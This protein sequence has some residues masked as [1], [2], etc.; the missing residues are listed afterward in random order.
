MRA[1]R[2]L[3][4]VEWEFN[5]RYKRSVIEASTMIFAIKDLQKDIKK[6]S[7]FHVQC[8]CMQYG[9]Y[10]SLVYMQYGGYF[11]LLYYF[12]FL[13]FK[14]AK[15]MSYLDS[16]ASNSFTLKT[17]SQATCMSMLLSCSY[18]SRSRSYGQPTNQPSCT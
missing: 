14:D 10:F 5:N 1:L 17:A 2:I 8:T 15:Y 3:P 12:Y 6:S 11:S 9:G 18:R 4:I 7:H 13:S 16:R